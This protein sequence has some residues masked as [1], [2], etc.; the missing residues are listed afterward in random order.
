MK[1][2]GLLAAG[3]CVSGLLFSGSV[4]I[5]VSELIFSIGAACGAC[6]EVSVFVTPALNRGLKPVGLFATGSWVS[7]LLFSG[8][9]FIVVSELIFSIGAAC[10]ACS[11][12]SVFVTPALN[13]GLKPVGLFATGSWVS[14]LLFSGSAFI[15]VSELIFSIGAACGACSEV[16]V[17]VTPALNLGLNPVGFGADGAVSSDAGV[18]AAASGALVTPALNRGLNPVGFGA[19][20]VVS[21]A[22]SSDA[23]VV[24][25]AS[26]ALV[27][28][29][30][31]RGLNPVGFGA[32]GVVSSA[33]SSDAGVVAAASGALVTPALNRGLN[34]VGFGADGVVSSAASSDAGVVAAASGALVT[35]ALNR[36]LNPVGF[37][38][39]GVVSSVASSDAGVVAAASGALVTPALNR[40][41]NPVGA[42]SFSVLAE[43]GASVVLASSTAGVIAAL[44]RGLKPAGFVASAPEVSVGVSMTACFTA[45]FAAGVSSSFRWK[46]FRSL[47]NQNFLLWSKLF[48]PIA[49]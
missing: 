21:S 23:G 10:G 37:G 42:E 15:V 17:F 32:D 33:A 4:F 49:E 18:V 36:G 3:S 28:P 29:A 26:G 35:P 45:G 39:D 14:E 12:V 38:A 1:P 8:S 6:S 13:R 20:G 40:G 34:P 11:E 19:D 22:A 30:L 31:N 24:A 16:S 7:E 48:S 41:L 2:I 47:L 9:A 27:T 25:A 43:S 46:L 44:N 5:V